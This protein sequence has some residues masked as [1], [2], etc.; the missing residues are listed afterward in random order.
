MSPTKKYGL[1]IQP[2]FPKRDFL[3]TD[4]TVNNNMREQ[5]QVYLTVEP[6]VI[7]SPTGWPSRPTVTERITNGQLVK[8][9]TWRDARSGYIFKKGIISSEP[10]KKS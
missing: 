1:L 10:V 2:P 7:T 5:K 4:D 6:R 3:S 8:E 9:A